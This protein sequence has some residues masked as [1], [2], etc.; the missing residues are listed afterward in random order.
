MEYSRLYLNNIIHNHKLGCY[1]LKYALEK[2]S[3]KLKIN[4]FTILKGHHI[5]IHL[6]NK[7][8][9]KNKRISISIMTSILNRKINNSLIFSF[10]NIRNSYKYSRSIL[11]PIYSLLMNN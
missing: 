9:I 6:L 5:L 3:I 4:S 8:L 10:N 7:N 1:N 11:N 2:I